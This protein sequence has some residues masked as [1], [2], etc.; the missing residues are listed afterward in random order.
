MRITLLTSLCISICYRIYARSPC[1]NKPLTGLHGNP[2]APLYPTRYFYQRKFS[3]YSLFSSIFSIFYHRY[4]FLS[5]RSIFVLSI[6]SNFWFNLIYRYCL[7]KLAKSVLYWDISVMKSGFIL[8][9]ASCECNFS[10]FESSLIEALLRVCSYC[11]MIFW[12]W[13]KILL[14][15]TYKLETSFIVLNRSDI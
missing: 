14:R 7:S 10:E 4:K 13:K 6:I 8:G 15:W 5:N 12:F 1:S 9:W 11:L 2:W 3:I